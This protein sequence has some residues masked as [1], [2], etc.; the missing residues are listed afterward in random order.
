[1]RPRWRGWGG[2][3]RRK[4]G[5]AIRTARCCTRFV[6]YLG[7]LRRLDDDRGRQTEL[8]QSAV[9]AMRGIMFA[10]MQQLD[11]VSLILL[12]TAYLQRSLIETLFQFRP[13]RRLL[14]FFSLRVSMSS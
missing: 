5:I 1:M 11:N 3:K 2:G 9:K 12:I 8:R 14:S 10:W 13:L 4:G 6:Q 7:L